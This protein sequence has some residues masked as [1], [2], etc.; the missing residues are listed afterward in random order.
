MCLLQMKS[1]KK[2]SAVALASLPDV[3]LE[4]LG[5]RTSRPHEN[6]IGVVDDKAAV[7]TFHTVYNFS[8]CSTHWAHNV[9]DTLQSCSACGFENWW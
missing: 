2:T 7:L 1:S 9:C 6:P 3:V 5:A 4:S 8:P